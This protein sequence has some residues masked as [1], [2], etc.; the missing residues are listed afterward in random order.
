M[1]IRLTYSLFPAGAPRRTAISRSRRLAARICDIGVYVRFYD[2]PREASP[3]SGVAPKFGN[4]P[5]PAAA[6]KAGM[7]DGL[8]R[9]VFAAVIT[10]AWM[11]LIDN[12]RLIIRARRPAHNGECPRDPSFPGDFS[13][14][15]HSENS[16]RDAEP[17]TR[18]RVI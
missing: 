15:P 4:A 17:L 10:Q 12:R 7:R 16:A 1:T 8:D 5:R 9:P 3:P 18:Y 14:I 6:Y 11:G 2:C 13:E